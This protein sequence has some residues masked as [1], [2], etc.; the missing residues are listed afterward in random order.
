[1]N[2]Q[3]EVVAKLGEDGRRELFLA[4]AAGTAVVLERLRPALAS[5]LATV[6]TFLDQAR[7]A[8]QLSHPNIAKVLD[9]G[10]LGSS[11]YVAMEHVDGE[12]VRAAVEHAKA[13]GRGLQ[14]PLRAVLTIAAGVAAGLHHAH[15]QKGADGNR[16]DIVHGKLS[17]TNVMISRDGIVKLVDFG[18]SSA[19]DDLV[20]ELA[21]RSPEQVRGEPIDRRSDLFSI[22]VVLWEL[23][24]REPLFQRATS[25]Q[26]IEA[27]E[28]E[29]APP[30]STVRLDVPPELDA[31]ILKCLAKAPSSRYH[32]A[33]E[34]LVDIE[35][36]A[37]K[38][39][40]QLSTTDLARLIRLWFGVKSDLAL[41]GTGV[42][43]DAEELPAHLGAPAASPVD[44]L[45]DKVSSLPAVLPAAGPAADDQ[46]SA[47]TPL[48]PVVDADEPRETFEQIRDRIL[49]TRDGKDGKSPRA[50]A[51]TRPLISTSTSS[52]EPFGMSPTAITDVIARVTWAAAAAGAATREL[53]AARAEDEANGEAAAAAT[54]AEPPASESDTV[55]APPPE[56][57]PDTVKAPPPE[58]E[59]EVANAPP[60]EPEVANAPPPEPETAK[61]DP[62]LAVVIPSRTQSNEWFERGER[63]AREA[64]ARH[65]HDHH[66]DE[67]ASASR[68]SVAAATTHDDDHASPR[69]PIW[70]VAALGAVVVVVVF[71]IV[72]LASREPAR[73]ERPRRV[74]TLAARIADASETAVPA[75]DAP[76]VVANPA[77]AAEVAAAP[78]DAAQVAAI[79]IDAAAIAPIPV[80]AAKVAAIPIDAA[81]IAPIPVDAAKV[82]AIP[83]D[84]A[85][86]VPDSTATSKPDHAKSP[87]HPE[88]DHVAEPTPEP[89]ASIE[90]LYADGNF[91]K[92]NHACA[93]NT[94]FDSARLETCAIVACQVKDTGLATRWIRAISRS[95]RDG[96]IGKCKDLGVDITP[97][98]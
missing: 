3:Y 20:A 60:P 29:P 4:R 56:P 7:I 65:A 36:L 91:A 98:Q 17:P 97:P 53:V 48:S 85:R 68:P 46:R 14:L 72:K 16:L 5:D 12:V 8:A 15:E 2:K 96:I 45:L 80:D 34:L 63:E 22:G 69:R 95:T 33:D 31:I 55:K 58:P 77:D 49:G 84:A 74:E 82:A 43:V 81:A 62:H 92:A 32:D 75:P 83:N 6:R 57:E 73:N 30:P 42:V 26:T 11:Y 9:V 66:D 86:A 76:E 21:Y 47:R 87:K 94:Q 1:M 40:F 18:L 78:A 79:P 50:K 90:Q 64:H 27:I 71:A 13:T 39:G 89:P 88:P 61:R 41:V 52:F 23:L 35:A 54:D 59:P 19:A 10:K 93:T 44:A 38:L 70:L 25:A 67:P 37:T 24:A 51:Y 28:L